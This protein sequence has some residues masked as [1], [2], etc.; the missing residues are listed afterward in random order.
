MLRRHRRLFG[1][2]AFLLLATPLVVGI[3]RPDSAETI[4]KEGRYPAP[5]PEPPERPRLAR[6]A[7]ADGRLSQ[8][9]FRPARADDPPPPGPHSS[10]DPQG[11]HRSPHRAQRADVLSGRRN[12][13][14]ERGP[15]S[16]GR[17]RG[18]N[19]RLPRED[20]RRLGQARHPLSGGDPAQF[21]DHLSG[22]PSGLGPG[23]RPGD[24]IRSPLR[25]AERR[26]RQDG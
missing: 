11:Q 5:A 21:L 7:E 20:A 13:A 9:P 3:V 6:A 25:Q 26:W 17:A 4:L 15:R 18:A 8:R 23:R 14:P 10:G 1:V 19:G 24:G 12:G 2:A 22:R 16:E